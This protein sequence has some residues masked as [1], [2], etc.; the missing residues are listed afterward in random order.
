M[1]RWMPLNTSIWSSVDLPEIH[2]RHLRGTAEGAGDGEQPRV[3]LLPGDDP[4]DHQEA[5]EDRDYYTQENVFWVPAG[6]TGNP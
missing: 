5:L 6:I 4:A 1:P 3:R 2:L